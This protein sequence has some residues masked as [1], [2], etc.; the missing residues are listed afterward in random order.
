[1]SRVR[2]TTQHVKISGGL[3]QDVQSDRLHTCPKLA[4]H[5]T[6]LSDYSQT[7]CVKGMHPPRE[8]M[9][10]VRFFLLCRL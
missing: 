2:W 9:P 1:M 8:Q 6:I 5:R 7:R 3:R 10:P 4:A